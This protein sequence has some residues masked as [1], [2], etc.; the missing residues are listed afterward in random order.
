MLYVFRIFY[1]DYKLYYMDFFS[2]I[3]YI[4]IDN[5]YKGITEDVDTRFDT[6]NYELDKPL[7]NEKYKKVIGLIKHE[8]DRKIMTRFVGLRANSYKE[9]IGDGTE[10]KKAQKLKKGVYIKRT[11]KFQIIKTV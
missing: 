3:V 1:M 10:D 7:P 6:S 5:I 9:L 4:K 11:F 8:L 2:F